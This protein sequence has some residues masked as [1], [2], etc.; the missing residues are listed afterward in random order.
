LQ[1][2]SKLNLVFPLRYGDDG[3]PL[4]WVHHTPIST[5]VFQANHR[6]IRATN[7]EI[8]Q[9]G[10]AYAA[11]CANT[12]NLTLLDVSKEDAQKRGGD[13]LGPIFLQELRR[14]TFIIAPGTNGFEMI[15]VDV[16][17]ARGVIDKDDLGEMESFLVFFTVGHTPL[18]RAA[19][20]GLCDRIA[21]ALRGSITSL[22]PSEWIDFYRSSMQ[23]KDSKAEASSLP[24]SPG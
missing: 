13:D 12:A 22:T 23:V 9:G 16:A 8:W 2:D 3:E 24:S 1:I 17:A 5:E 11:A 21:S 18:P 20:K 14:L 15:P 19:R 4:I 6:I 7:A 10:I